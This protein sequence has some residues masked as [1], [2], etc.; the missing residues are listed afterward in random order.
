MTQSHQGG[1]A[2]HAI[3]KGDNKVRAQVQIQGTG[4]YE[5]IRYSNIQLCRQQLCRQCYEPEINY[6]VHLH[7]EW[8]RHCLNVKEAVYSVYFYC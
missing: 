5:T 3:P 8:M 7:V 6:G 1:E 2:S 4:S